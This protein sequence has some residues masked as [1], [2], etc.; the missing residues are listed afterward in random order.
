MFFPETKSIRLSGSGSDK[1]RIIFIGDFTSKF[2]L[3]SRRAL[4][5]PGASI[6][7][8]CM[9]KADI[10]KSEVYFTNVIKTFTANKE[11]FFKKT[12]HS[13]TEDSEPYIQE[14]RQELDSLSAEIICTFGEAAFECLTGERGLSAKR[15]YVFPCSLIP[16]KK[17]IGTYH[18]NDII[19]G[20]FINKYLLMHDLKKVKAESKIS[21]LQRPDRNLIYIHDTVQYAID[22]LDYFAKQPIVGFD[23][24][25]INYETA[26]ISF[27]SD[28]NTATV[29]P[30]ANRWNL[31]EELLIRRGIQKVLGNPD[32]IKVVQNGGM[33]DIPFLRERDNIVVRGPIHDTMIAHSIMFPELPKGLG[34]LGSLYCGSQEYWK[35]MVKFKNIKEGA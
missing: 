4:S 32:S 5:G 2:D 9:Y 3:S 27:S 26:C 28:P 24:E 14:L 33:F 29:I 13:L 15:G 18:P 1:A 6:L 12:K 31:E 30:V 34:F 7:D 10:I 11:I 23:I 16:D 17:V 20:Q 21:G 35:N 25:V 19:R 22:W 8:M